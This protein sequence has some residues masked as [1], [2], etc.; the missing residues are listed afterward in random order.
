MQGVIF[1]TVNDSGS[2]TLVECTPL[3]SNRLTGTQASAR[4]ALT[5]TL[6]RTICRPILMSFRSVNSKTRGNT[7]TWLRSQF[8]SGT[9]AQPIQESK[10]RRKFSLRSLNP[11]GRGALGLARRGRKDTTTSRRPVVLGFWKTCHSESVRR[12]C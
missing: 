8:V 2:S 12:I 7:P 10:V 1:R 9:R 4:S 5:I 6:A 3:R 11:Y